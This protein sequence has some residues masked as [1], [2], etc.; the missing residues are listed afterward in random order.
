MEYFTLRYLLANDGRPHK[1]NN[2]T[3]LDVA[4]RFIYILGA[5]YLWVQLFNV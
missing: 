5:S 1:W 4:N 2:A 3:I